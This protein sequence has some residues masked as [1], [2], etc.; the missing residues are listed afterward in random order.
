MNAG[1]GIDY[2]NIKLLLREVPHLNELNIGHSIIC[3]AVFIGLENAVAEM[4]A[5]MSNYQK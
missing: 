4:L 3:R 2:E 1:H 5:L